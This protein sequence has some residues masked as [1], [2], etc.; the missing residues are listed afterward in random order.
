MMI[1]DEKL[2]VV[3]AFCYLADMSDQTGGCFNAI[4]V[5]IDSA[6]KN[7]RDQQRYLTQVKRTCLQCLHQEHPTLR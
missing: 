6:W 1:G 5:R 3:D 2:E 7:F 4:T